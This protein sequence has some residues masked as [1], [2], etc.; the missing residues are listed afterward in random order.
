M[1]CIYETNMSKTLKELTAGPNAPCAYYYIASVNVAGRCFPSPIDVKDEFSLKGDITVKENGKS[2]SGSELLEKAVRKMERILNARKYLERLLQDLTNTWRAILV[3]LVC[4]MMLALAWIVLI[5][6]MAGLMVWTGILGVLAILIAST[7][8][9]WYKYVSLAGVAGAD[10]GLGL[11]RKISYYTGRRKTWLILG[12]L[13][14]TCLSILVLVILCLR[15]RVR[16]ATALIK[17]AAKAIAHMP[18]A[19]LFPV[20]P[21]ILELMVLLFSAMVALLLMSLAPSSAG[22]IDITMYTNKSGDKSIPYFDKCVQSLG[23]YSKFNNKTCSISEDA[24]G[25]H[26]NYSHMYNLF[27]FFWLSGFI[28]AFGEM[29][30]ATAIASYYWTRDK[31]EIP[32]ITVGTAMWTTV[33]YHMGT[34]AFGSLI[35][36]IVAFIRAIIMFIE[37]RLKKYENEVT[38]MVLRIFGCFCWCLEN[39][40]KFV[41]RNAYIMT[42]IYGENFCTSARRAFLLLMR[43]IVR[44]V[45]VD[46]VTDFLLLASKLVVVGVTT[47]AGYYVFSGSSEVLNQYIPELNYPLFPVFLLALGS[48]VIATCFFDVYS[49]AVDTLFLCFLED[50]ERHDGSR[51]RPYFMSKELMLILKKKESP[52]T[53]E[54]RQTQSTEAKSD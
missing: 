21:Y 15:E 52:S 34:L 17:E 20:F 31:N 23:G 29:T 43:N 36:S 14:T 28:V 53:S 37:S 47:V 9:S 2:I 49:M 50:C 44:V 41:N 46:K 19:L 4:S 11:S 12:I 48:Y 7:V 10:E 33:R 25:S 32:T 26:V 45:V 27:G 40:L 5:R 30:L 39:F 38:K 3:G 16:I 1:V 35:I 18:T 42:G 54:T 22:G 24:T 8:F 51:E 6:Y 13:S